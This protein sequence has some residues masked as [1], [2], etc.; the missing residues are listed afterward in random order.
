M[1]RGLKTFLGSF[2]QKT[3]DGG[4][5]PTD[6]IHQGVIQ[7]SLLVDSPCSTSLQVGMDFTQMVTNRILE[8]LEGEEKE[9]QLDQMRRQVAEMILTNLTI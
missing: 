6:Q 3:K 9:E 5:R 4:R 7:H 2:F 8:N 1:R